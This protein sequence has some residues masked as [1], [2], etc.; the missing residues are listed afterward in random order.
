MLI[1]VQLKTDPFMDRP[2]SVLLVYRFSRYVRRISYNKHPIHLSS[3]LYHI[4]SRMI[5]FFF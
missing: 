1:T 2:H 4:G 5:S 3:I